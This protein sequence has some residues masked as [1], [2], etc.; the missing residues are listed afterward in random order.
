MR[1]RPGGY[2]KPGCSHGLP[3]EMRGA[4]WSVLG[5]FWSV[6]N[7]L[8]V[9]EKCLKVKGRGTSLDQIKIRACFFACTA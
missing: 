5:A 6:P 1:E 8:N 2:K 7:Q 9:P 4:S 3:K